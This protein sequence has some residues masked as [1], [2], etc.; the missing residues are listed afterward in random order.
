MICKKVLLLR[1][2]AARSDHDELRRFRSRETLDWPSLLTLSPKLPLRRGW[3]W[4][5]ILQLK[6]M[7]D[8]SNG[9]DLRRSSALKYDRMALCPVLPLWPKKDTQFNSNLA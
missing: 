2:T 9:G 8:L 7:A 5:E 3:S 1:P 6:R 4:F